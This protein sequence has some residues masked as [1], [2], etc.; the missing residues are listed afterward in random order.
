MGW[1][2]GE[3][4]LLT[5]AARSRVRDVRGGGGGRERGGRERGWGEEE[6]DCGE[7]W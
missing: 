2:E 6:E 1:G 4:F 3:I 7:R 5:T